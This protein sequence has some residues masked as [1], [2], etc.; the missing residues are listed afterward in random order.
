VRQTSGPRRWCSNTTGGPNI[1]HAKGKGSLRSEQG[2]AMVHLTYHWRTSG[3]LLPLVDYYI[4]VP[5]VCV[6]QKNSK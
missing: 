4:G 1:W 5:V 6:G 3:I 2:R